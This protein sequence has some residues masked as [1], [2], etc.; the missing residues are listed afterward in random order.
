VKPSFPANLSSKM[1]RLVVLGCLR[2]FPEVLLLALLDLSRQVWYSRQSRIRQKQTAR[3]NE[4]KCNAKTH[5]VQ[6]DDC[7]SQ[8]VPGEK[9]CLESRRNLGCTHSRESLRP[10]NLDASEGSF[11]PVWFWAGD[12]NTHHGPIPPIEMTREEWESG[13]EILC[14]RQQPSKAP[15]MIR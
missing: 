2:L 9:T 4:Q 10:L 12:P 14:H 11:L 1:V 5:T 8:A 6:N 7:R 3:L 15:N 13:E